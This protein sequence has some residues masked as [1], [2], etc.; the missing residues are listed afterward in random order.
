VADDL[1]L[2]VQAGQRDGALDPGEGLAR[3]R[4]ETLLLPVD[5]SVHSTR[6][7][8]A[9]ERTATGRRI[10]DQAMEKPE[11]AVPRARAGGNPYLS[12]TSYSRRGD[13][14]TRGWMKDAAPSAPVS[15]R[16]PITR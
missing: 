14:P 4:R 11:R 16:S 6:E 12:G 10:H 3:D 8:E 2:G 5:G 9:H 13:R 1:D 15:G 7:H